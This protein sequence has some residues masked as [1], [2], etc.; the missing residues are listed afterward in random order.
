MFKRKVKLVKY[1]EP[2]KSEKIANIF[3]DVGED[4]LIWQAL[5]TIIDNHLLDAVNDVSDPQNDAT[6]FAHGAGRVDAISVLKAKI[7][8]F[9]K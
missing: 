1:P 4:S 5:D 6:K 8:E 3:R 9:R 7:E 2:M